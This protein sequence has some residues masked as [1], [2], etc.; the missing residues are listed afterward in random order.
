MEFEIKKAE[1][2][3]KSEL[4]EIYR[5]VA[6]IS[7]GIIRNRDE[8]NEKY[9][10]DFLTNSIT[11][12]LILIGVIDGKIVGEI[13]AYTP[14]IF[15]FQHV[16]TD[17]TIIVDPNSQGKGIGRKLFESFLK[18]VMSEL[19][20]IKRIELYTREH[21]ERNVKFYESLGFINE[22]RQKDK[23]F[24]SKWEFE[25][26]LHMVWFNPNYGVKKD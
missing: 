14:N 25:T 21:N 10:S 16:L 8:I 19:T 12:G 7:D 20:H 22:G 1:I 15:A 17:L 2:K 5:K 26:P 24:I 11:N 3:N 23:I 4:L 18:N 6:K 13:H 9:V